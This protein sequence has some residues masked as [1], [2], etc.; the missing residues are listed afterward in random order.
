MKQWKISSQQKEK[1]QPQVRKK[2]ANQL[3]KEKKV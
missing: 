1:N 2:R 3:K